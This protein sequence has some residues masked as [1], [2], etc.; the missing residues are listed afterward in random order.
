MKRLFMILCAGLATTSCMK[1]DSLTLFKNQ[2][3]LPVTVVYQDQAEPAE[4]T[5]RVAP[6]GQI[7]LFPNGDLAKL[8]SVAFLDEKGDRI[9]LMSWKQDRERPGACGTGCE[10]VW[11]G[12]ARM[13]IEPS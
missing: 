5:V 7:Y 8:K 13:T 12:D 10:M 4:R 2:S 3:S 6:K 1:Q 11:H 9:T